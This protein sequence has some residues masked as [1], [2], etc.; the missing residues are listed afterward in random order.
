MD[1]V[2]GHR[3]SLKQQNKPFK[4]K[5]SAKNKSG[6]TETI[7]GHTSDWTEQN[8]QARKNAAAQKR[9]LQRKDKKQQSNTK[10]QSTF[11]QKQ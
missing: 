6:R 5:K 10:I 11:H 4:G 9:K 3:A 8:K 1:G 7:S 2:K